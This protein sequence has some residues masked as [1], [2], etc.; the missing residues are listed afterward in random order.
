MITAHIESFRERLEELKPLLPQHWEKLAL[1]KDKVPL[2]PQYETY[3]AR[4]ASGELLFVALRD[5]GRMIGYW[6]ACIA[7]GLHYQTCL[8]AMMDIWNILPEY[9]GTIAP[10]I[11]MRAV[12]REYKRR[13]V[14]RSIVGEKLHAPCGRLF[15]AF[16]Y[17]PVERIYSKWIGD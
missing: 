10:M 9:S 15:H 17:E 5:T 4:E 14:N 1:H 6:I 11:L 8:T 13:G 7:P 3:F 2:N 12:E 16:G